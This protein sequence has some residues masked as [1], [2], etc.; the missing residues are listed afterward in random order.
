MDEIVNQLLNQL[1]HDPS[2]WN[3]RLE[4]AERYFSYQAHENIA[5]LFR[6]AP[7]P[8]ASQD[9]TH[10]AV[11]L[12]A[13]KD[14][15]GLNAVLSNFASANV[16][17][18][19]A[20]H[21][22][23]R[24]LVHQSRLDE[25]RSEYQLA[26]SLDSGKK[27]ADLEALFASAEK[28]EEE[29]PRI[30]P[31]KKV[32]QKKILSDA[33]K[34]TGKKMLSDAED[35]EEKKLHYD[36]SASMEDFTG[37]A[38]MVALGEAVK[39]KEKEPDDRE[40]MRAL[41]TSVVVH[42][43]MFISFAWIIVSAAPMNPPQIEAVAVHSLDEDS[44]SK[45]K[46]KRTK[47][48]VLESADS[49]MAVNLKSLSLIGAP[50]FNAQIDS[51][52][53]VGLGN[54]GRSM[55][56][57][58]GTGGG[59]VSFFGSK[60]RAKR[61][62]FVVD[63]SASMIG[64]KEKLMRQELSKSVKALP[65]SVEYAL[66][67]FSGPAWY[68]GQKVGSAELMGKFVGN[69]VT[70]GRTRYVWYEGWDERGRHSGANKTALHHFSEGEDRLPRGKYM[71]ASGI[72]IRNSLEVI[73]STPLVF[74]TDWRWPLK[75]AMNMSPDVIYFM[76]DGAFGVGRGMTKKEMITSLLT[77]NRRQSNSKINTICMKVLTAR[78]ELEQLAVGSG[79]EFTLVKG[80]GTVVRGVDLE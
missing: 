70:D 34:Q 43:I 48:E 44:L 17:N 29:R 60:T 67:F 57:G 62:V 22:Y 74:G 19:W 16:Q 39:P 24:I 55:S 3:R 61:V 41:I 77:Y 36:F 40:K 69:T 4:L 12:T 11:E 50:A 73:K 71:R 58:K 30:E 14:L 9:Q 53:P 72:N 13:G 32:I 27:D 18:A 75:M 28:N 42:I 56:F 35:L 66:I 2:D 15:S 26:V 63:F 54:Y 80:D 1:A 65:D 45:Q 25:A 23:A 64:E 20:H 68:A 6:Q 8:P 51:F 37:K 5:E 21:V 47:S 10:R 59:T 52:K 49:R 46:V 33:G 31:E 79:G 78:I 38:F 7:N 76:T